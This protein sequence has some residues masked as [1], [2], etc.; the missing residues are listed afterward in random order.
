LAAIWNFRNGINNPWLLERDRG[1]PGAQR[2][3][4]IALVVVD[5]FEAAGLAPPDLENLRALDVES[6]AAK[7]SSG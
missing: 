2:S 4:P 3:L 5:G 1:R 6:E 7:N